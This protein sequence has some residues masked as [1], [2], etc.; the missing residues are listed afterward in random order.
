M[1]ADKKTDI[2]MDTDTEM[3]MDLEL[4]YFFMIL[5]WRHSPYSTIWITYDISWRNPQML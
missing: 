2:E 3:D 5:I 4:K 1:D